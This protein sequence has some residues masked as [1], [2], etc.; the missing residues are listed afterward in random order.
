MLS[1]SFAIHGV[2]NLHLNGNPSTCPEGEGRTQR[3]QRQQQRPVA[4]LFM[5][6]HLPSTLTDEHLPET[7]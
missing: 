3:Q 5:T 1:S 2:N 6:K 4:A 7:N